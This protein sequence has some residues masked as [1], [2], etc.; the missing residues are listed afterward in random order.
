MMIG[1]AASQNQ[2]ETQM[3]KMIEAFDSS[4]DKAKVSIKKE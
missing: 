1:F 2:T 3:M 4:E